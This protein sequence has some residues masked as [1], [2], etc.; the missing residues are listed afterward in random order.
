MLSF[1]VHT[2][3]FFFY[4]GRNS[5]EKIQDSNEERRFIYRELLPLASYW[6]NIGGLLGIDINDLKTIQSNEAKVQDCLYAMISWW[7]KQVKPPPTWKDLS[8]AVDANK[9][10]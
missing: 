2:F 4:P 7:L 6:F 9:N 8:E 1:E 5:A 3:F 10:S